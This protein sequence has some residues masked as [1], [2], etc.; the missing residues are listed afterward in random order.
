[1]VI[2]TLIYTLMTKFFH[3]RFLDQKFTN[4]TLFKTLQFNEI[5]YD[6]HYPIL[7]QI[8]HE[9]IQGFQNNFP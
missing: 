8:D 9:I 7:S 6:N 2:K 3:F 1:M 4:Q 5:D